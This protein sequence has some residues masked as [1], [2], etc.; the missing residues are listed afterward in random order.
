VQAVGYGQGLAL[1]GLLRISMTSQ[2]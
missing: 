2:R 1:V